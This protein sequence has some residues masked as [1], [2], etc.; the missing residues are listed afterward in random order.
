ML[1]LLRAQVQSLGGELKSHKPCGTAKQQQENKKRSE[2][3]EN[4]ASQLLPWPHLELTGHRSGLPRGR[5]N[6][7]PDAVPSSP[8]AGSRSTGVVEGKRAP[9][10]VQL[11]EAQEQ[12]QGKS[13]GEKSGHPRL[14]PQSRVFVLWKKW[15]G[16]S[17]TLCT[18]SA[19]IKA[20]SPPLRCPLEAYSPH[21]QKELTPPPVS[22]PPCLGFPRWSRKGR[23][24]YNRGAPTWRSITEKVEA[25]QSWEK[26][27]LWKRI[28]AEMAS[29]EERRKTESRQMLEIS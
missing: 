4:S 11:P 1:S 6:L 16:V 15:N 8:I 9:E 23:R 19:S 27:W 14:W 25:A 20:C 17:S 2:G 24:G 12:N 5:L 10:E 3:H 29:T 18:T 7:L 26:S 28:L 13:I 21:D 22:C